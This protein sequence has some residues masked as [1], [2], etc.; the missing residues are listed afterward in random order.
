MLQ[1]RGFYRWITWPLKMQNF[2]KRME[3]WFRNYL[4]ALVYSSHS[5]WVEFFWC[6][7]DHVGLLL[8]TSHLPLSN[9]SISTLALTS[10]P[11]SLSCL[12]SSHT[13]FLLAHP[14]P[15]PPAS[16]LSPN[17]TK[18]VP[19][20]ESLHLLMVL[21]GK[22]FPRGLLIP[23]L[24]DCHLL[25]KAFQLSSCA[26][27]DRKGPFYTSTSFSYRALITIRC[28]IRLLFPPPLATHSQE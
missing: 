5:N 20:S 13:T 24:L 21:P 7:A 9:S 8:M 25:S 23:S 1:W 19:T 26:H 15:A 12:T 18:L 28:E 2:Y 27:S 3:E 6:T 14:A 4:P 10:W 22:F 11:V 16:L 17:M